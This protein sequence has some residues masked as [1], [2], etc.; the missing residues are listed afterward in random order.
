[1]KIKNLVPGVIATAAIFSYA[2]YILNTTELNAI[3]IGSVIVVFG[4]YIYAWI[5]II[6]RL[7][8]EKNV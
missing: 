1:M 3:K 4:I 7:K 8:K 6:K 5:I 2:I